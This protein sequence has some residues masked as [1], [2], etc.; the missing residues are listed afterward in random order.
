MPGSAQTP[1]FALLAG[2]SCH[3]VPSRHLNFET[4][5]EAAPGVPGT[6][7]ASVPLSPLHVT[8]SAGGTERAVAPSTLTL[9]VMLVFAFA[10]LKPTNCTRYFTTGADPSTTQLAVRVVWCACAAAGTASGSSRRQAAASRV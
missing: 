5:V 10:A 7:P 6:E 2:S 4:T 1:V 9:P 3:V 8:W